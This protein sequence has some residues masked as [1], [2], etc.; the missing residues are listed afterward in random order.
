MRYRLKMI[1]V[2]AVADTTDV[3]EFQTI[4]DGPYYLFIGKPMHHYGC[5]RSPTAVSNLE[6]RVPKSVVLS[7]SP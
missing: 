6:P 3:I 2:D 1:R 5:I 4:R 7:A